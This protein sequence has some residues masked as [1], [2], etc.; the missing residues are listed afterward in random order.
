MS[1]TLSAIPKVRNLT[2]D[3]LFDVLVYNT[4]EF[5]EQVLNCVASKINDSYEKFKDIHKEFV[6]IGGTCSLV[7]HSLGSV[8]TWDLLSV[9]SDNLEEGERN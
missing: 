2:N 1:T 3:V 4:P 7:G 9:L 8:I 6:K 5:C